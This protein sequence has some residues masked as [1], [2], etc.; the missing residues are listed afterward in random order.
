LEHFINPNK[1]LNEMIRVAKKDAVFLIL[2]P[3]K[4]FLTRKIGLFYG[5]NQVDA[6]EDVKTLDEWGELFKASGLTVKERWKDLHVL[7]WEWISSSQW[8]AIPIRAIQAISLVFW[9]LSWQYQV[10]HLCTIQKD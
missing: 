5:T 1:A 8:Y 2:V 9:P 6:K 7:S 4:D 10:Y 3:N